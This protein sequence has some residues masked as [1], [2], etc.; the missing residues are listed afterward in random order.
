MFNLL[1]TFDGTAWETDQLMRMRADRF[2]ISSVGKEADRVS[3]EMPESLKLLEAVPAL[4][5]YERDATGP[6]VDVVR[7]GRLHEIELAGQELQFRFSEEGRLPR[8]VVREFADWL[9]IG[10]FGETTTHWAIKAGDIPT[11]VLDRML[12]TYDVVLSFAGEDRHYVERVANYLR[13]QA[14]RVFYDR[15]EEVKL[16]GKDL[17]EH[18]DSVYRQ[19]GKYCVI[20]VS[21]H[22]IERMWTKHERQMALARKLREHR[23]YIL[24]VRIDE[25]EVPGIPHSILYLKAGEHTPAELG[26]KILIKLGRDISATRKIRNQ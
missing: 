8:S 12:P 9:G 13:S 10:R 17:A 1:V 16:W 19:S 6:N 3:K 25:T 26:K 22:Y 14:V 11:A 18:F 2:K 7:Y 15:Y 23:E 24:P 5:M 4:L 20:F 21:K